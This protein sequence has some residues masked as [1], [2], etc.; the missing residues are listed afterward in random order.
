MNGST[1]LSDAKRKASRFSSRA[2]FCV[3]LHRLRWIPFFF[4]LIVPF[5][6]P[7][8]TYWAPLCWKTLLLSWVHLVLT[9]FSVGAGYHRFWSHRAYLASRVLQIPMALIGSTEHTIATPIRHWTPITSMKAS[10]TPIFS[11]LCSNSLARKIM[12]TYRVY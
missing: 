7:I 1:S 12:S 9:G 10:R 11:G 5:V 4:T 8:T 6:A 3:A 2:Y